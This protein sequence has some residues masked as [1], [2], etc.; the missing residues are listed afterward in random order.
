MGKRGRERNRHTDRQTHTN[1][2]IKRAG[3]RKRSTQRTR[4]KI[5]IERKQTNNNS[6]RIGSAISIEK[7]IYVARVF[8]NE[9][10]KNRNK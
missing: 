4:I 5:K 6:N 1:R 3:I 9:E 7:T 2:D 8:S 10:R